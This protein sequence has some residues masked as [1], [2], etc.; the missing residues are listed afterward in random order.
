MAIYQAYADRVPIYMIVGSHA[1]AAER[2]SGV[3]SYHSAN[4]M[5]VLVRDFTKWDDSPQLLGAFG[6][7][8][9]RAYKFAMTPPIGRFSS[10]PAM[11]PRP[12]RCRP[13]LKVPRL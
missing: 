13:N 11:K 4:D 12:S 5:G 9:V 3:A 10:W 2:G 6:E 8:A 1:D 7:S